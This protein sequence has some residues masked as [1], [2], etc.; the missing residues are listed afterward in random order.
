[1]L[2][3]LLSV[4][5]TIV[6]RVR[7]IRVKA[8]PFPLYASGRTEYYSTYSFSNA[9]SLLPG[10]HLEEL[11]VEDAFHGFGL[12]DAWRDVATYMDIEALIKSDAWKVL[13]YMTPNTDFITSG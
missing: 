13:V 12:G 11:V 2:D 3:T 4:N 6:T 5:Q 10:L 1:M 7:R 9:L 8:F